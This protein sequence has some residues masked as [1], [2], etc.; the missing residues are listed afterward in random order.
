MI[1]TALS[2][3]NSA[4]AVI[5]VLGL[6]LLCHE[7]GHFAFAKLFN[8]KVEEFAFGFGRAIWQRRRGETVYRWNII[9]FG[10]YVRIAGMEPGSEDVPRGF[11]AYARW[12]GALVI[13]AGSIMNILLALVLFTIV[14]IWTGVPDPTDNGIYINKISAGTPASRVDLKPGDEIIAVD[15]QYLSLD[16]AKVAPNSPAAK[17]GLKPRLAIDRVG[18]SEVFTPVELLDALA[19]LAGRKAKVELID[20]D[21]KQLGEEFKIVNLPVPATLAAAASANSALRPDAAALL[22]RH[23][24]LT[25]DRLHQGSLVG[26]IA[27]RPS[28]E[29]TVTVRR[30]GQSLNV[31]VTTAVGNGRYAARDEKGMLYSRIRPIGRIGVVLRGATKPVTFPEAIK[32]GTLRTEQAAATVIISAQM[33]IRRQV[34]A[35]LAGPVAIMAISVERSRIGWDA[36]LNWGG[37]I[38]SILAVMNLVPIPPFDGFKAVLI[39]IE[40]IIRQRVSPKLEWVMSIM[41]VMFVLFLFVVLTFKDLSNLIRFG[42]P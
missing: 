25:F 33:M 42:T 38:S 1:Q 7:A 16:I 28:R 34:E 13:V 12:K 41:G 36:V 29:V 23:L 11:H 3:L 30:D 10:G 5:V 27:A 32:I 39:G 35:E 4:A 15:D 19:P 22:K 40:A 2:Y 20:Y 26:Y 8:M 24:G 6:C 9:P 21:A 37:I 14:T 31:P 18:Q 17:A